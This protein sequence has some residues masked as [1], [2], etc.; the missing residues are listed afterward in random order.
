ME[1]D[2][3]QTSSFKYHEYTTTSKPDNASVHPFTTGFHIS[4]SLF[5]FT[6]PTILQ[7]YNS[8][9]RA[10]SLTR[11]PF[12]RKAGVRLSSTCTC[13]RIS[14][15][16]LGCNWQIMTRPPPSRL[17]TGYYLP[18]LKSLENRIYIYIYLR[19]EGLGF[20]VW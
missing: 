10:N 12:S 6:L 15:F 1:R 17:Q 16:F 9:H 7:L 13:T 8:S 18:D 5:P 3:S 2:D 11:W 19:V 4:V 14:R 20:G